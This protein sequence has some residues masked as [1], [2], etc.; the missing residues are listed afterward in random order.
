M[1]KLRK[2]WVREAGKSSTPQIPATLKKEITT[3]A[4]ELIEE[5]LKPLYIKPPPDKADFNYPID[6]FCQ[7]A[8]RLFLFLR[9]VRLSRAFMRFH[10]ASTS[11]LQEWNTRVMG[12]SAFHTRDTRG[13]GC[14][15]TQIS[16]WMSA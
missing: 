12:S 1:A 7:V 9:Q 11:S 2:T 4:Q 3:K 15:S 8:R 10:R 14:R 13:S 6:L 16:L 5:H